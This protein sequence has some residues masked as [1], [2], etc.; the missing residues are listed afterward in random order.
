M[1]LMLALGILGVLISVTII[2]INPSRQIESS[3]NAKRKSM[4]R[5]QQNAVLQYMITNS[6]LPTGTIGISESVATPICQAGVTDASCINL[7]TLVPT[8]LASLP[9]DSAVTGP[10]VTGYRIY[11]DIAL[12]PTVCSDYLPVGD[13]SRCSASTAGN[14]SSSSSSS[15]SSSSVYSSSSS[16][17]NSSSSVYSSSLSSSNSSSSIYSSSSS[18]SSSVNLCG[19][20]ILDGTEQ[21]DPLPSYYSCS[22]QSDCNFYWSGSICASGRCVLFNNA[23]PQ[24]LCSQFKPWLWQSGILGC[25]ATFCEVEDLGGWGATCSIT[26]SSSSSSSFSSMSSSA[27]SHS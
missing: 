4:I 9:V 26:G 2:A 22:S 23:Y 14:G 15:N 20:G 3:K 7:D 11:K 6:R 27:S 16:S 18:S 19:N 1:E 5:E 25:S 13:S 17:S 21:C 24:G 12:K 8:Y 10:M